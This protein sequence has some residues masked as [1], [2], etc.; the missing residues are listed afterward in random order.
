MFLRATF[1]S[2]RGSSI[3]TALLFV[4]AWTGVASAQSRATLKI[5]GEA[6]KIYPVTYQWEGDIEPVTDPGANFYT[7]YYTGTV[8]EDGTV[9]EDSEIR[10]VT[11]SNLE[12]EQNRAGMIAAIQAFIESGKVT[13][14]REQRSLINRNVELDANFNY[15][16]TS[17]AEAPRQSNSSVDPRAQ[18]E[19]TFFYDQ[20]VLWQYYCQRII[21]NERAS[22]RPSRSRSARERQEYIDAL[23]A[24]E[25]DLTGINV[26]ELLGELIEGEQLGD[27]VAAQYFDAVR[28]Y[29][30]FS[31]ITALRDDFVRRADLREARARRIF[32]EMIEAID[33]REL[34]RERYDDWKV[35]KNDRLGSFVT[36]WTEVQEGRLLNFDQTYYLL[37]EEPVEAVPADARSVPVRK[38]LTPQDLINEDGQLKGP[39]YRS[40]Y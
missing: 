31:Q 14:P 36:A 7:F 35:E 20:V 11:I 18:A 16:D 39:Q 29:Q 22:E 21:L 26:N 28:D 2:P 17:A 1:P 15:V 24:Y 13:E 34:D 4:T 27:F 37:T 12:W 3:L 40:G 5:E 6:G 33:A 8:L 23:T 10:R 25:G 9:P 38:V 19:W 30:D 32:D